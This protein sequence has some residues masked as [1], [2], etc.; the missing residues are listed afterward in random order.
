MNL[1]ITGKG[2]KI[3]EGIQSHL[4]D[5]INKLFDDLDESTSIYILLCVEKSR[6]KA[7]ITVKTK[8]HTAHA[9]NETDDLYVSMDVV[10]KKIETH[11]KKIKERAQDLKIKSRSKAKSMM[12]V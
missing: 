11:L 4:D 5:K 2:L 8:G 9:T 3:T 6:H 7:E 10:L 1:K 12:D